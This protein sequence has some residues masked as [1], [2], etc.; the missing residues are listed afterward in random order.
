MAFLGYYLHWPKEELMRLEHFERR[1]WCE[2]IS[3]INSKIGGTKEG[4][5]EFK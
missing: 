4:A 2:E 5:V 1:R 3:A